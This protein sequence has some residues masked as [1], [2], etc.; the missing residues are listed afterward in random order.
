MHPNRLAIP[1]VTDE[2]NIR[3]LLSE[4]LLLGGAAVGF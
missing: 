1:L 3:L 4:A 2:R